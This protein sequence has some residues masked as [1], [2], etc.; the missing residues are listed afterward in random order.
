MHRLARPVLHAALAIDVARVAILSAAPSFIREGV[1]KE[2]TFLWFIP[3][4]ILIIIGLA[5]MNVLLL[6]GYK[7]IFVF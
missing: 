3:I 4:I 5:A 6:W 2:E 1:L 7:C